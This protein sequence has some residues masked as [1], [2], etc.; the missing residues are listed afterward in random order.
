MV[1]EQK[2][3]RKEDKNVGGRKKRRKKGRGYVRKRRGKYQWKNMF[4][5]SHN[6]MA[7]WQV[8]YIS[9]VHAV[10]EDFFQSLACLQKLDKEEGVYSRVGCLTQTEHLLSH[11]SLVPRSLPFFA[12]Q[13]A[14]SI[15]ITWNLLP[16]LCIMAN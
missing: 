11:S 15:I 5:C 8:T 10:L 16:Y 14:F 6:K 7:L 13:L 2:G 12:L 1:V 4:S 3:K 9:S